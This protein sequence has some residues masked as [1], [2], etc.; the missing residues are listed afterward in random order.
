LARRPWRDGFSV[1]ADR[2][3]PAEEWL[4]ELPTKPAAEPIAVVM[5]ARDAPSPAFAGGGRVGSS[6]GRSVCWTAT[7]PTGP[8]S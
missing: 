3:K 6:T 5:A 7:I 2:S 1:A 8:R 4:L